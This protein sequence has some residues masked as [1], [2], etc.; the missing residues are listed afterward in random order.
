MRNRCVS[1]TRAVPGH[2]WPRRAEGMKV[3]LRA[4]KINLVLGLLYCTGK[5]AIVRGG[6]LGGRDMVV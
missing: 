1:C 5:L 2:A 4:A 6:A 3:G